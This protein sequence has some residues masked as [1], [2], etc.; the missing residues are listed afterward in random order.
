MSCQNAQHFMKSILH[1]MTESTQERKQQKYA[2]KNFLT[3]FIVWM[4]VLAKLYSLILNRNAEFI[5]QS[6]LRI[7][8]CYRIHFV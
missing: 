6:C 1:A 2:V 8:M 4:P 3:T 5:L 7:Y